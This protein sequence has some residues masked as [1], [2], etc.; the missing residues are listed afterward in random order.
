MTALDRLISRFSERRVV[1]LG[2]MVADEYLVGRPTRISREAPV[3][4]LALHESF[5]RPG[6]ATNTAYN[7]CTLGAHTTVVGVI[8]D[9]EVGSRLTAALA[10][11]GMA[12]EGLIVDPN[13]PT[14][15]SMR[16]VARGAQDIQQ[17]VVRVDRIERSA[18]APAVADSML[19][20]ALAAFEQADA[21][22]FSDYDHGVISEE[23]I[24]A[25]IPRARD[26]GIAI[27]VD[28]HG[29]LYR[30]KGVTAAT[31]N[32]PEA[33]AT[34][35][36]PLESESELDAAGRELVEG[37]DAHGVLVTRGVDGI[38]LYERGGELYRL[39]VAL[40]DQRDVVDATGAG[41]T[42]AAAFTLAL[43][44]GA[45]MRQAA[46]LAN[47]AGGAAVRRLGA[48]TLTPPE[49]NEALKNCSLPRP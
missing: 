16:V 34:V 18:V 17:Q 6:G 4:I 46:Y 1:V 44:S 49:L 31:P 27:I 33:A 23:L 29:D 35:G 7:L 10:Q 40:A 47:V 3:L 9:D 14:S 41:D 45:T 48:A 11:R 39:P 28:S 24:A 21:V 26:L 36:R 42:V 12:T 25:C 5:V 8:G 43:T 20:R 22:V 19:E 30:F 38:A 13:R 37:M 15:T 32:Q 2:D